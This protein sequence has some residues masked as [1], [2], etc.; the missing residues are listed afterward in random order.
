[1]NVQFL[2]FT[3]LLNNL[4]CL[5]FEVK[6]SNKIYKEYKELVKD[7]VILV[8]YEHLTQGSDPT[9]KFLPADDTK[10]YPIKFRAIYDIDKSNA[11][12]A[13]Y[14]K[15]EKEDS[16][17]FIASK[18]GPFI[19]EL[20]S[21]SPKNTFIRINLY[22]GTKGEHRILSAADAQVRDCKN[23]IK[24]ALLYAK[25]ISESHIADTFEKDEFLYL[26][27]RMKNVIVISILLK[28]VVVLFTHFVF[29]RKMKKFWAFKKII[30]E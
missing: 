25:R 21:F 17:F 1:M 9:S 23:R 2:L 29:G 3:C 18:T 10:K 28:G 30:N 13:N 16:F 19:F 24:N 11:E 4:H 5:I 15:T 12:A 27:N 7:T 22:E 6:K 20:E 8:E 26:V 14:K